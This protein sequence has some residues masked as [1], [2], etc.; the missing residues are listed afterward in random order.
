MALMAVK[1]EQGGPPPGM[2]PGMPPPGMM[3]PGMPGGMPPPGMM[4]GMPPP[5]MFPPGMGPPGMPPPGMFPGMPPPGMFPPGMGPPGPEGMFPGHPGARPPKK[6]RL[7]GLDES[8]L[9]QLLVG[10]HKSLVTLCEVM[11]VEKEGEAPKPVEVP[12]QHLEEEFEQHWHLRFDARAVGEQ[13]TTSFLRRFP[14]V[15]K[16]RSN[17]FQIMVSP[18]EDPNF[19]QAAEVGIEQVDS[20]TENPSFKG[21]C[22]EQVI[23]LLVNLVAED[24]KS[25]GAPLNFQYASYE[26][27]HDLMTMAHVGARPEAEKEA[28]DALLDPKPINREPPKHQQTNAE[29]RARSRSP[30]AIRDG[31]DDRDRDH[32]SGGNKGGGKGY[33]DNRA[34][35]GKNYCRKYQTN[36]CTFGANCRFEHAMDPNKNW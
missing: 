31:H 8:S 12:L 7:K 34:P 6:K 33:K 4:P 28:I 17:G 30:P 15:F 3:P 9:T 22:S 13:S 21:A 25:G 16:V 27:V 19:E 18:A 26:I 5:G 23:S 32:N 11:P 2:M 36:E 24:R 14:Q 1:E 35:S 29:A 10:L 20:S